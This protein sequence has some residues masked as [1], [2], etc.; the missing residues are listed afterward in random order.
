[1]KALNGGVPAP[2]TSRHSDS[3]IRILGLGL[4]FGSYLK[5]NHVFPVRKSIHPENC[6]EICSKSFEI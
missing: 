2:M 4:W 1:V 5:P 6:I 3:L